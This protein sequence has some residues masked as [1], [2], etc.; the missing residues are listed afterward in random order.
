MAKRRHPVG[1]KQKSNSK[2]TKKRLEIKKIMLENKANKN[3]K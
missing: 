2:K 1:R 3:S